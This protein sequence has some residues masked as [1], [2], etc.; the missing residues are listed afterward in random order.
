[1]IIL[2]FIVQF[3]K[4]YL[5]IN[6]LLVLLVLL[7]YTNNRES[8]NNCHKMFCMYSKNMYSNMDEE[9]IVFE[10][11]YR[12]SNDVPEQKYYYY[13]CYI[14]DNNTF[15]YEEKHGKIVPTVPTSSMIRISK[16]YPIFMHKFILYYKFLPKY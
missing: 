7:V 6:E 14:D 16:Y 10:K 1:M 2:L 12:K 15:R 9:E 8:M 4:K 5:G 13:E 3:Y 11:I